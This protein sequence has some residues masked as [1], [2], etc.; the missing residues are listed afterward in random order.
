MSATATAETKRPAWAYKPAWDTTKS[1][2]RRMAG[3]QGCDPDALAL[4]YFDAELDNLLVWQAFQIADELA[5]VKREEL[6]RRALASG[7]SGHCFE[8]GVKVSET[9]SQCGACKEGMRPPQSHSYDHSQAERMAHM[10]KTSKR[11]KFIDY[12]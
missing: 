7:E 2:I 3:E 1:R 10:L 6:K 4:Q 12:N 9:S 8:C 5:E 11:Q